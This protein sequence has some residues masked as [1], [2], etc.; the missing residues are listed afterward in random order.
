MPQNSLPYRILDADNHFNEPRHCFDGYIDPSQR[1]LAIRWVTDKDGRE[2]Q[3]FAGKPSKFSL[4]QITFSRGELEAMLGEVPPTRHDPDATTRGTVP[5]ML[6]NRLNPLKGLDDDTRTALVAELRDQFEACGNRDLRLALMDEQGI[7]AALMFPA[8]A[9]NIEYEFIDNI[10]ALYAN[11]RAFNR[12]MYEEVG[13]VVEQRMFLPPYLPL[14]DVE[15]AVRE[16]EILLEQ[17]APVIQIR[18]GHAHGGSDNPWGG[19]SPADPVFDPIWSRINEAG[20]QL[21]V[22][23]GGTDYQ[24]YGAD[25]SENPDDSLGTFDAFQYVMY[26]SDRPAMELVAGLILH[27]FFERFPNIHVAFAEQ[28]SVWV[29]YVVR[30]M[31]HAFLLGRK[32][33]WGTLSAR[34]SEIFRQHFLVAPYPE[35]NVN[36][37]ISAVGVEPIAFGSDFPHGEGLAFPAQYADTQLAGLPEADVKRIMRDNLAGYLGIAV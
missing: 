30:K 11:T 6:L 17:G 27:S 22:H 29:P 18:A 37:V 26:W 25:W 35:E 34:P 13:F 33:K 19:R 8:Q 16:L 15:L 32:A 7:E 5:G 12:W 31:D 20:T 4:D 1:D 24:K 36:R 21:A 23:Q 2:I 9:H 14:A 3:L 10:D 28:G